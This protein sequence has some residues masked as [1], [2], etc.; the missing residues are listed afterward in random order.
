M[1]AYPKVNMFSSLFV[2]ILWVVRPFHLFWSLAVVVVPLLC[3]GQLPKR[4]GMNT[5]MVH[6]LPFFILSSRSIND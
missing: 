4:L 5:M 3:I 1:F 6:R 2:C